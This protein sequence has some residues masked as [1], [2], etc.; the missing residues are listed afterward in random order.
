MTIDKFQGKYR[1]LS[2]FYPSPI[3]IDN[4]EVYTVEHLYQ[5]M[6]P[7]SDEHS[8]MVMQASTPGEAKRL[9]RQFPMVDDWENIKMDVMN[10]GVTMKFLQNEDLAK[11]LLDTGDEELIEGNTWGDTFWG[12]CKGEGDNHLGKILMRVRTEL[13]DQVLEYSKYVAY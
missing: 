4:K 8:K 2:N 9:G 12:V 1:F 11:M 5:G 6:K 3:Q 7:A 13:R 10:I